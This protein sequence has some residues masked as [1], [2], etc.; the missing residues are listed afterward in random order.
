M[1][2][3][4][5][6]EC[7]PS[8]YEAYCFENSARIFVK[9][10]DGAKGVTIEAVGYSG[11]RSKLD[12]EKATTDENGYAE[13]WVRCGDACPAESE[14]TFVSRKSKHAPATLSI[15]CMKRPTA[16][17]EMVIGDSGGG[18]EDEGMPESGEAGR[19]H[20][21]YVARILEVRSRNPRDQAAVSQT[22]L[23]ELRETGG[24]TESEYELLAKL[25][26]AFAKGSGERRVAVAREVHS[27][28]RASRAGPLAQGVASIA[29]DSASTALSLNI[30]P[31]AD[32]VGA[33]VGG[34]IGAALGNPWVGALAGAIILSSAEEA[35]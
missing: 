26:S 13:F 24:I 3:D 32:L 11:R 16:S 18:E 30:D 7:I 15:K 33:V 8:T 28:L 2:G 1:S 20:H 4:L 25:P 23:K 29:V 9:A 19:I 21:D 10:S 22:F 6:L 31:E 35:R 12:P 14:I 5:E 27:E 17:D 34:L